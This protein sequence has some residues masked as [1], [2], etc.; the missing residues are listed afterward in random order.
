MSIIPNFV[1]TGTNSSEFSQYFTTWK[2]KNDKC[3]W[4]KCNASH[5]RPLELETA[6]IRKFLKKS[7]TLVW[8]EILFRID[9]GDW[10]FSSFIF[11]VRFFNDNKK[12]EI[13]ICITRICLLRICDSIFHCFFTTN[14]IC[15]MIFLIIN[16]SGLLNFA[17]TIVQEY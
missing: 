2:G 11:L 10:L 13:K 6:K 4:N 14:K 8:S 9:I 1:H 3:R 5:F 15:P 17:R 16:H 7:T 12:L